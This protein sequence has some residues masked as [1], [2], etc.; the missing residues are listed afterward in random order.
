[1]SVFAQGINL[2]DA[3]Q[4]TLAGLSEA[5]AKTFLVCKLAVQVAPALTASLAAGNV[6]AML[7][8]ADQSTIGNLI[9]AVKATPST[10]GA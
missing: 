5:D 9:A 4:A 1:M 10:G 2:T 6:L 8:P 3:D 7:S